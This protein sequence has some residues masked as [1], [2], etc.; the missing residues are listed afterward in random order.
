LGT[1]LWN[2]FGAWSLLFLLPPL[3]IPLDRKKRFLAL[4]S[5][6]YMAAPYFLQTD[7]LCLM[8]FQ[9]GWLPAFAS[10]SYLFP[11]YGM[12][13]VH[14]S[15]LFPVMVYLTNIFDLKRIRNLFTQ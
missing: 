6:M 1:T 5:A 11:I 3:I 2:Y 15:V 13:A 7:L 4:F 9:L 14:L 10:F 12:K 8:A